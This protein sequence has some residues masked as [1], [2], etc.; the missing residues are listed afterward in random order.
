[1]SGEHNAQWAE[2]Q[3]LCEA[4]EHEKSI[5]LCDTLLKTLPGD[6]DALHVKLTALIHLDRFQDAL[7]ILNGLSSTSSNIRQNFVFEEAYCLYRSEKLDESLKLI[8]RALKDTELLDETRN[9]LGRLQFQVLYR[10]EDYRESWD[11]CKALVDELDEGSPYSTELTAN[12]AGIEAAAALSGIKMDLQSVDPTTVATYEMAYNSACTKIAHHRLDEAHSL[13]EQARRLCR[14]LLMEDEKPEEDIER[15]LAIIVVQLAYVA[16]LQGQVSEALD[17]YQGVL[18]SKV[19][20]TAVTAVASNNMMALKKDHELFDSAKR[21]RAAATAGLDTKLT[22][23]QK[24]VIAVNGAVLSMYMQ[25]PSTAREVAKGLLASYPQDEQIYLVLAGIALRE[26]KAAR[27]IEE[28]Q[29]CSSISTESL[30]MHLALAQLYMSQRNTASAVNV[31]ER[32]LSKANDSEKYKPGLVS[33]MIWLYSQVGGSSPEKGMRLLE[34]ASAFWPSLGSGNVSISRQLAAFKLKSNRPKEAAADFEKL[35]KAEPSDISSVAGLIM[36]Y[37][38]FNPSLAEKYQSY[39]PND[40]VVDVTEIDVDQLETS[41]T[42]GKLGAK[43][44]AVVLAEG[45]AP[46]VKE[47]EKKKRKRKI[48]LPKNYDPNVVP[49]PERW[50]PK[51]ERS[52]FQ[53]KGKKKD[54]AKGSQGAAAGAGGGIGGTG[55]AR[56]AGLVSESP[57]ATAKAPTPLPQTP[58]PEKKKKGKK[59]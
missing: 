26:N 28:L 25:K 1:M 4:S 9:A 23:Q 53:K 42:M 55:S 50:L 40:D 11:V 16:Q 52:A 30:T 18:K 19:G 5:K 33:F 15:E 8:A 21:Y 36:S 47:K 13:L 10:T 56:I 35:V 39:L 29:E 14:D 43:K 49:D 54:L 57:A 51:R 41:F 24:K 3:R 59:R 45:P 22:R 12:L 7:N 37:S 2:L 38:E 46:V 17:L 48:Q 44:P 31:M 32:Y 20:D 6:I 34:Q 27:A 58:P